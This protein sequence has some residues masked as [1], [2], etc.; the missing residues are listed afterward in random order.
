MK[1][2]VARVWV[3]GKKGKYI[4]DGG[5]VASNRYVSTV[6]C[7]FRATFKAEHAWARVLYTPRTANNKPRRV[8]TRRDFAQIGRVINSCG[9]SAPLAPLPAPLARPE[10]FPSLSPLSPSLFPSRRAFLRSWWPPSVD[11]SLV[12]TPGKDILIPKRRRSGLK[13]LLIRVSGVRAVGLAGLF[14][15]R[16]GGA[17]ERQ[18]GTTLV[19][20]TPLLSPSRSSFRSGRHSHRGKEKETRSG[21]SRTGRS[22]PRSAPI[23]SVPPGGHVHARASVIH[24]SPHGRWPP[25][26]FRYRETLAARFQRF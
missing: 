8:I 15:G 26:L 21:V 12:P 1:I 23:L 13:R 9:Q 4:L 16:R 11:L 19:K 22:M 7:H 2:I 14:N 6:P 5:V 25:S 17:T 20:T 10:R 18:G 3:G 24:P